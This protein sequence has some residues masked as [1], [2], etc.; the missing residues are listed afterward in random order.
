MILFLHCFIFQIVEEETKKTLEQTPAAGIS[1]LNVY[2]DK[3][4]EIITEKKTSSRVRF[5]M[6]DVI[7]LRAANWVKR[8]EESGPKMID[9]IHKD[10]KKEEIKIKLANIT[11]PP[12]SRKS[13]DRGHRRSQMGRRESRPERG[14]EDTW[15][16]VPTRAAK[17]GGEKVMIMIMIIM[18]MMLR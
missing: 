12:P 15:N 1:D 5:L 8:R 6:Q 14:G 3:M 7:D 17:V 9:Q 4:R 11:E 2:F 13:E 18:M 10:A 16:N